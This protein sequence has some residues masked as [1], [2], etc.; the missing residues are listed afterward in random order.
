MLS[1]GKEDTVD[2]DGDVIYSGLVD[3]NVGAVRAD[4]G[5]SG[6]KL[7]R[8]NKLIEDAEK[9]KKRINDLKSQGEAGKAQAIQEQWNDVLKE[10]AGSKVTVNPA[11]IKKAIKRKEKIKEKSAREWAE[12][13]ANLEST[14]NKKIEKREENLLKRKRG[15]DWVLSPEEEKEQKAKKATEKKRG[16]PINS[17][18]GNSKSKDAGRTDSNFSDGKKKGRAGFEGKKVEFLNKKQKK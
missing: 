3:N 6:S 17:K 9:K 15:P 18:F 1:H 2:V 10:A 8:L 5:K 13:T 4:S 11:K 14:M 16:V 7:R 12:R